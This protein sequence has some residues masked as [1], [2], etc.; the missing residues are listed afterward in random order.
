MCVC[1]CVC[2]GGG[3]GENSATISKA[4]EFRIFFS[5]NHSYPGGGVSSILFFFF[6]FPFFPYPSISLLALSI[7]INFI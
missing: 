4:N 7:L 3:G 2:G 1:V 6:F 5:E